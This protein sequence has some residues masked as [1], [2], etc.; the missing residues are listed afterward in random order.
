VRGDY[1]HRK[2]AFDLAQSF[3]QVTGAPIPGGPNPALL[4]ATRT[5]LAFNSEQD[6][7]IDTDRYSA[8]LLVTHR[9]FR[10]TSLYGQVRYDNQNSHS[11]TLGSGTDFE[12]I[13]ATFGV[14][15]VF[16]PITL[17]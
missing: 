5:G 8:A 4:I 10:T 12:T 6:V 1:I 3:D 9:L 2:S 13:L 11:N 7:D 14:R 16:E 15:H 17:W